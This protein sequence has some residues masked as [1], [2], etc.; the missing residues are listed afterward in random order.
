MNGRARDVLQRG[1]CAGECVAVALVLVRAAPAPHDASDS[2]RAAAD[3]ERGALVVRLLER[4]VSVGKW[5][6]DV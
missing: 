2:E 5:D 6:S 3:S 4:A 1:G